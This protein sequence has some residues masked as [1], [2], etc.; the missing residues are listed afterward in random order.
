MLLPN[1]SR[2]LS[3]AAASLLRRQRDTAVAL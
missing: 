3:G 1:V 2:W